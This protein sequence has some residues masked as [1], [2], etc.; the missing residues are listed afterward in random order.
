MGLADKWNKKE[1][2]VEK[3]VKVEPIKRERRPS[4]TT[5]EKD[6]IKA[7]I[8]KLLNV[9]CYRQTSKYKEAGYKGQFEVKQEMIDLILQL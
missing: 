6:K 5:K 1:P 7:K 4:T 2:E 8:L 3:K 9:L